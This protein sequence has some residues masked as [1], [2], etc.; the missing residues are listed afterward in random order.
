MNLFSFFSIMAFSVALIH[1]FMAWVLDRTSG[2][3]RIVAVASLVYAVWALGTGMSSLSPDIETAQIWY[4]LGRDGLL[5]TQAAILFIV[6][7]FCR[8]RLSAHRLAVGLTGVLTLVSIVLGF[9]GLDGVRGFHL[10][11]WGWSPVPVADE[12]AAGVLEGLL[13]LV[14]L[15]TVVRAFWALKRRKTD[16]RAAY[17]VPFLTFVGAALILGGFSYGV[18]WYVWGL[19]DPELFVAL[20][21]MIFNTVY[22]VRHQVIQLR[23]STETFS[24]FD[25]D[26]FTLMVDRFGRVVRVSGALQTAWPGSGAWVGRTLAEVYPGS[27]LLAQAWARAAAQP[28]QQEH[29]RGE[30]SASSYEFFLMAQMDE[31]GATSGGLISLFMTKK[32]VL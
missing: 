4:T 11:F 30:G 28:L 5:L 20:L 22:L 3:A 13:H 6:L 29:C 25:E 24:W 17:A 21:S 9:W 15:V 19:P 10:T 8:E 27:H 31:A 18:V 23:S 1:A 7:A 14:V 2:L 26:Q 12:P 32:T 16:Y